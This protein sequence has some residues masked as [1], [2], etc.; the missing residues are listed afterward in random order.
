VTFNV[1]SEHEQWAASFDRSAPARPTPVAR[2]D[3]H[4]AQLRPER[5][6]S[7]DRAVWRHLAA[8]MTDGVPL[9]YTLGDLAD[10]LEPLAHLDHVLASS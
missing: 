5:Y 9:P 8:A 2:Y 3:E 1:V 4:G 6:E 10:H 7:A